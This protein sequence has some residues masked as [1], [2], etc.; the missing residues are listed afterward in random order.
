MPTPRP[1]GLRSLPHAELARRL[2]ALE[3]IQADALE[4]RLAG[5][6]TASEHIPAA[7]GS[8]AGGLAVWGAP[9]GGRASPAAGA[10]RASVSAYVGR[11]LG[12][13]HVARREG[14][15][16]RHRRH[17]VGLQRAITPDHPD[18]D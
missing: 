10:A 5:L 9:A 2:R 6:A 1:P 3:A 11:P 16:A 12:G 4:D 14:L 13:P 8:G 15:C 18:P 7:D 17:A